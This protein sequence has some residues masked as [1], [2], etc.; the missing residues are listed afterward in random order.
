MSLGE[1]DR[2]LEIAEEFSLADAVALIGSNEVAYDDRSYVKTLRAKR[3]PHERQLWRPLV[4]QPRHL[5]RRGGGLAGVC[6]RQGKRQGK[7]RA[8]CG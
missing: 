3:L 4:A 2:R 6:Q 1:T 8:A 7:R 5:R